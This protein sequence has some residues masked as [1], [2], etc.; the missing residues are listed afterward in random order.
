MLIRTQFGDFDPHIIGQKRNPI[1]Q[2]PYA[3]IYRT[4]FKKRKRRAREGLYAEN[5][6]FSAILLDTL[7]TLYPRLCV[8]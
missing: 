6:G 2:T 1:F 5:Y 4:L 7:C 3:V 8:L